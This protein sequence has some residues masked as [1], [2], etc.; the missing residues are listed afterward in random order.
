MGETLQEQLEWYRDH[1]KLTGAKNAGMIWNDLDQYLGKEILVALINLDDFCYYTDRHGH[2]GGVQALSY[3]G[4]R[5]FDVMGADHVYS[6]GGDEFEIVTEMEEQDFR[7]QLANLEETLRSGFTIDGHLVGLTATIGYTFGRLE[8]ERRMQDFNTQAARRMFRGKRDGKHRTYGGVFD[9][10][11]LT[12]SQDTFMRSF[13]AEELDPLTGLLNMVYFRERC[14][15]AM[16]RADILQK[17][18]VIVYF[19]LENFKEFNEKF[20]YVTGDLLL[21]TVA[22]AIRKIFPGHIASRFAEDH[23]VVGTFREGLEDR[24]RELSRVVD[25]NSRN[26]RMKLRAGICMMEDPDAIIEAADRAKIAVDSIKNN[27]TEIYCFYDD[28][29]NSSVRH[30]RY[31][32]DHLDEAIEKG[33][34]KNYYQPVYRAMTGQLCGA[35][36]L[37]RWEDPY[38]GVMPPGEFI[39]ILESNRLIDKLDC[40]MLW[41]ICRDY[42]TLKQKNLPLFP[43]SF[44]LSRLDFELGDIFEQV[45]E[46]VDKFGMPRDMLHIEITESMLIGDPEYTTAQIAKFRNAGYE[47]WMDDFGSGFSSLNVL[48]DYQFDTLKIDMLFL[49]KV[50]EKSREI[51]RS[52]VAMAKNIGVHTLAE[53]VETQEQF[54]FLREIGCEKI[55]GYYFGKP[56]PKSK[57]LREDAYIRRNCEPLELRSYYDAIGLENL[58]AEEPTAIIEYDQGHFEFLYCNDAYESELR[59]MGTLSVA[60]AE[61]NLNKDSLHQV[62]IFEE[63]MRRMRETGREEQITYTDAGN[64][65]RLQAR[66]LASCG[67]REAY[68]VI[69]ENLTRRTRKG[70]AK[71]EEQTQRV[72]RPMA[73]VIDEAYLYYLK[74]DR[75]EA[76]WDNSRRVEGMQAVYQGIEEA[77]RV[78]AKGKIHPEDQ[79][80]YLEFANVSTY[81][82]RINEQPKGY[83][84]NYFRIMNHAGEYVWKMVTILILPRTNNN[85]L[86]WTLRDGYSGTLDFMVPMLED[87]GHMRL[88]YADELVNPESDWL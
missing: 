23:F 25:D 83:I 14:I 73:A 81:V 39:S 43:V 82:D 8:D 13:R 28:R 19:N 4:R 80:R 63:M 16:R 50:D 44:N 2:R 34:I 27:P 72:L 37:A 12:D 58:S 9:H 66:I 5:L 59:F 78:Y 1:N 87:L 69:F 70:G 56:M 60:Q 61:E 3:F 62:H 76:I 57:F 88:D 21:K 74:E 54:E 49:S 67:T 24:I 29:L 15:K 55:Q 30:A 7:N 64:T 85:V 86:I 36:A 26:V 65:M 38:M 51:I 48:K 22:N 40:Y 6:M 35:E 20:G 32:V 75:V 68:R 11:E 77:E 79:E 47:V 33:W 41:N 53:G 46:I 52:M 42:V 71:D 84:S 17:Q 31:V 18:P 10:D 45:E